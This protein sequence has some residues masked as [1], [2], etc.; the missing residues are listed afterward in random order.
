MVRSWIWEFWII[1]VHV[2]NWEKKGE[3]FDLDTSGKKK[4]QSEPLFKPFRPLGPEYSRATFF[5]PLQIAPWLLK[6]GMVSNSKPCISMGHVAQNLLHQQILSFSEGASTRAHFSQCSSAVRSVCVLTIPT[7][8]SHWQGVR[9]TFDP[10]PA[11]RHELND[12]L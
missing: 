5:S 4:N 3:K 7:A 9:T 8:C 11:G 10:K 12:H 6:P 1:S 2:S